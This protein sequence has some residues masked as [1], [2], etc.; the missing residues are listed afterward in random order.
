MGGRASEECWVVVLGVDICRGGPR[1][2]RSTRVCGMMEVLVL[3][4]ATEQ[5]A[6][7]LS[8]ETGAG[9]GGRPVTGVLPD[10]PRRRGGL[11]QS[12]GEAAVKVGVGVGGR[13]AALLGAGNFLWVSDV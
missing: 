4:E 12:K 10:S 9:L 1:P 13:W 7:R 5:L 3:L 6:G 2:R 11:M 8:A